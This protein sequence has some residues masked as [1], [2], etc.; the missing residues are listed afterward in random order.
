MW[1]GLTSREQLMSPEY[2]KQQGVSFAKMLVVWWTKKKYSVLV[3]VL[4]SAG[5]INSQISTDTC[6]FVLYHALYIYIYIYIYIYNAWYNTKKHVSVDICEFI[7]PAL[8]RTLTRT[9]YFFFVHH[10][11]SILAKLTP[12]C[13]EYSGDISCS[14]L[15]NP[16]HTDESW[17]GRN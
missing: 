2:S 6:F 10:T 15:V 3:S 14:L 1:L 16:S 8:W 17:E 9:E 12:C 11:T 5:W 7:H 13:F 4:Q